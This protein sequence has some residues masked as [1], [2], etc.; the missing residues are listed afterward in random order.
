MAGAALAATC[1]SA[2]V[3]AQGYPDK[4][5][6]IVVPATA[7]GVT[8]NLSR[9]VAEALTASLR[10]PV[11]V[12]NRPG[13]NILIGGEYVLRSPPDGYTFMVLAETTVG[14]HGTLSARIPY[15][16]EMRFAPVIAL[17]NSPQGL[18]VSNTVPASSLQEFINAAR[19]PQSTLSYATMGAGSTPY[20]NMQ[21]FMDSAK[22][23]MTEVP[24]KGAGPALTDIMGGH[25][26]SMMVSAGLAAPQVKAGKMKALA[27]NG[28]KRLGV[29]PDV[30]TFREAGMPNF[31]P[32]AWFSL[33]GVPGTPLAIVQKLNGELNRVLRDPEFIAKSL[34]PLGLEPLGGSP[35]DL[36]GMVQAELKRWSSIPSAKLE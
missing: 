32:A 18:F 13:A 10:Q 14:M 36:S 24:Y 11:I 31:T 17:A 27:V 7:G 16:A 3:F 20:I 6:K 23:K 5:I 9:A 12:E 19:N 29:L 30:P 34:T 22:V 8:D 15:T 2:G 1:S 28:V 33:V 26:S 35:A 21:M 4:P 25:V